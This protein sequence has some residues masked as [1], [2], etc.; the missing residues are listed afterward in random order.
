MPTIVDLTVEQMAIANQLMEFDAAIAACDDPEAK[1][2]LVAAMERYLQQQMP[3]DQN[4]A[5]KVDA[6]VRTARALADEA[7]IYD[8]DAKEAARKRDARLNAADRLEKLLILCANTLDQKQ[9][10]GHKHRALIIDNP[11]K[12][13]VLDKD[14]AIA[15]GFGEYVTA[16]PTP[17][18]DSKAVL[19]AF[20]ADPDSV[21]AFATVTRGQRAKLD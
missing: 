9:L 20:K 19:A 14:K 21:A 13:N 2:N 16:E 8:K 7:T 15:A 18:V 11:P 6:C 3:A 12:V 10:T 1:A 17:K 5:E 4:F